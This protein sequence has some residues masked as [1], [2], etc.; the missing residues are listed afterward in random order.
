MRKHLPISAKQKERRATATC[1]KAGTP[2]D[3]CPYVQVMSALPNDVAFGKDVVPSAQWA[4]ITSF[5]ADSA[6]HHCA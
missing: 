6:I 3:V 4:D 5:C 2:N 1:D